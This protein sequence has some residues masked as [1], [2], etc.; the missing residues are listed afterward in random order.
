M[1]RLDWLGFARDKMR[2]LGV[3]AVWVSIH[4]RG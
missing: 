4:L 1:F 3:S 2:G